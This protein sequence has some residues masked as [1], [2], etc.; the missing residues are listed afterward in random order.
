MFLKLKG[1]LCF[2]QTACCGIVP[3]VAVLGVLVHCNGNSAQSH[4]SAYQQSIK[5]REQRM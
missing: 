4:A 1:M 3:T 2:S 5:I